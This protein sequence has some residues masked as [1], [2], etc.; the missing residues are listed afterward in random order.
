VLGNV[1]AVQR[2]EAEACTRLFRD[3]ITRYPQYSSLRL[4]R[5]EGHVTMA[6]YP[7][8][9]TLDRAD[10]EALEEAA[11][12]GGFV[13]GPLRVT[14]RH[15]A[16]L[17]IAHR[18][19]GGHVVLATIDLQWL[20]REAA[21]ADLPA[22]SSV[23]VWDAAGGILLRY[24]EPERWIGRRRPDSRVF[25]A[26]AAS[27][28]DGTAEA[29]GVDGVE[30]LYGFGRLDSRGEGGAAFLAV[31]VPSV[32]A[33]AEARRRQRRNLTVL[34]AVALAAAAAS[35]F[36]G[37]RLLAPLVE[38]LHVLADTDPLTSLANRRAFV[39]AAR[40]E[41]WRA[42]RF[43]RPLALVMLDIDRFKAVN[44]RHGHVAGDAVLRE[45]SRRLL[46]TARD[47]DLVARYGGEEFVVLLPESGLETALATAERLRG[48]VAAAPIR[49]P[50]NSVPVTVSAG[51]AVPHGREADLTEWL[52]A[53]DKALYRA[54]ANGRNRVES[55]A[56]DAVPSDLGGPRRV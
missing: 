53:A 38:R 41:M 6:A 20:T 25:E 54:K 32:H 2:G 29:A 40:R 3:V 39:T 26:I 22:G 11:A 49:V 23:T 24:P 14:K 56:A 50:G 5:P 34:A 48:A 51:V 45:V 15:L 8:G 21:T 7:A 35:R 18:M 46:A 30:R 4:V 55:A 16:A 27:G 9:A 33:F 43:G 10:Q 42:H 47:A 52:Q 37:N 12:S 13:E 36:A 19:G 17:S 44:D 31:G 28:G 1:P